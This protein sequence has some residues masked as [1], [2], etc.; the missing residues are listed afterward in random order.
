MSN[1][2]K[3]SAFFKY[4]YFLF[5][6]FFPRF[7][8]ICCYC[9]ALGITYWGWKCFILDKTQHLKML[10]VFFPAEKKKKTG[11][12]KETSSAEAGI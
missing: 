2:K 10:W 3:S 11:N 12:G 5:F 6:F 4:L 8:D 1:Y 9:K 7:S